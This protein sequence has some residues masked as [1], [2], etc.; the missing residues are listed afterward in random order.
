MDLHLML[1]LLRK[2]FDLNSLFSLGLY[3]KF[4]NVN[5][6]FLDEICDKNYKF[7]SV[8][9]YAE[10]VF[11]TKIKSDFFVCMVTYTENPTNVFPSQELE[12]LSDNEID[13]PTKFIYWSAYNNEEEWYVHYLFYEEKEIF[14]PKYISGLLA[15][16][17]LDN[18]PYIGSEMFF[19]PQAGD[20]MINMYDDRGMDILELIL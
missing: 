4:D 12:Q 8:Y 2:K 7:D 5:R 14:L 18:K 16:H 19:I 17:L 13:I 11:K 1:E 20:V 9:S 6:I 15:R 3:N 10:K